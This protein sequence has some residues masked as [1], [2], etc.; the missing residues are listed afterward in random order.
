MDV[1][2]AKGPL[3]AAFFAALANLAGFDRLR[4][5]RFSPRPAELAAE[6][7]IWQAIEK[8][9]ILVHHPF[10]SFAI[11]E[12][13]LA[14]AAADERTLAI[15]QTLYRVAGDSPIIAAL[16][17]AAKNGKQVTVLMEVKAR[18]DEENNILMAR[19]LEEAGC[20][21]IYGILGLKTHSKITMVIRREEDGIRRYCHLAT[22][23]YNGATAKIYTD[24]G[25]FTADVLTGVDA[26]AFFNFLSGFSDP[27]V[28][29]RLAVAPLTL[30]ERITESI[31]REIAHAKRG[32]R[33]CIAAKMNS[34]LDRFIIAKLYEASAAGVE[35]DLIVRG[36]CVL[37]PGLKDVSENIRVRSIVGRF[38]EH[39]RIF[40]F[41]NGG[42]EDVFLS[43]ADWMPRNLNNRIELMT[44]VRKKAHKKRLLAL[45]ATY[46]ADNTR[47]WLMHPDGSYRRVRRAKG[48]KPRAAQEEL[49]K[50]KFL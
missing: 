44:P 42:K 47:A 6:G 18:F 10:D 13:F 15:K 4:Y 48:E 24:V 21:V 12:D 43:S 35:I 37:R 11:V 23:N 45:L 38:L 5:P 16:E 2:R 1:Y 46:L 31:E 25:L 27:P 17:E 26:S 50:C 22:G 14:R 8:D 9:D 28:W 40:C 34:L 3:G 29:N 32:E 41:Y 19:R 30:R 20:H 7:D 49:M 33:A 36:I 39:S